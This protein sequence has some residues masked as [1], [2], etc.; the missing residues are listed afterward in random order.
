MHTC[1]FYEN[2]H[3]LSSY[4]KAVLAINSI[5]C[6]VLLVGQYMYAKREWWC[7]E[8]L[9]ADPR[10][11]YDALAA[12]TNFREGYPVLHRQLRTINRHAF[13]I[14]VVSM[15]FLAGNFVMS[16]ILVLRGLPDGFY[17]GPRTA[18]GLITN[19]LLVLMQ[20]KA[21]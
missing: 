15:A 14:S 13:I 7:I 9:D 20:I 4:N 1:D 8:H 6:F 2:T 11:P 5:T 19:T 21:R 3:D 17:D 10:E 16:A 18:T 12:T